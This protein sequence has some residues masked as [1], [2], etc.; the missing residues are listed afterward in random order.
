MSLPSS[1]PHPDVGGRRADPTG[2][3]LPFPRRCLWWPGSRARAPRH[4][5]SQG[6]CGDDS[7]RGE[8]SFLL[9]PLAEPSAG[10]GHGGGSRNHI[11]AIPGSRD[12]HSRRGLGI[13]CGLT[14]RRP[15]ATSPRRLRPRNGAP[16]PEARLPEPVGGP[17]GGACQ[18]APPGVGRARGNAGCTRTA[19]SGMSGSHVFAGRAHFSG[20]ISGKMLPLITATEGKHGPGQHKCLLGTRACGARVFQPLSRAPGLSASFTGDGGSAPEAPSPS[21]SGW[22][23]GLRP[24]AWMGPRDCPPRGQQRCPRGQRGGRPPRQASGEGGG[25]PWPAG[26]CGPASRLV[27]LPDQ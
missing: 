3:L 4:L 16:P 9:S 26:S 5:L 19:F 6:G 27:R 12:G 11:L 22:W 23:P 13:T 21:S 20:V 2:A 18:T 7:A 1:F 17:G 10:R 8:H 25:S 14:Q 15:A 24:G